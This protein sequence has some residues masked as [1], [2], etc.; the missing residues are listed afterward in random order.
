LGRIELV[1]VALGGMVGGGI[2]SVLGVAVD[3]VGKAAPLAILVGG[4]FAFF[5]AYSY[6]KLA[7]YYKDEGATYSFFKKTYPTNPFAASVIGW[8]VV[9]GFISTLALYAFTFSSYFLSFFSTHFFMAKEVV[10]GSI[11][12]LF[13][14]VNIVSVEGMGVLEDI[15]VYTKIV[16]LLV[17]SGLFISVG[18]INNLSPI[19]SSETSILAI[20]IVASITFVAFE[21]F[22]LVIHAYNETQNPD[23]NVPFAI[24][25]SLGAALFI[26]LILAIGAMSAIP[27]EV[28]ISDKEYA[29]AAG[30]KGIIGNIG[31]F[32]VIFGALLATSSAISG[33]LFGASRLMAVIADDGFLPK[34]LSKRKNDVIP[35]YSIMTMS[36]LAFALILTGGLQTI[37]E[38]GSITF[39]IVSMLMAIA[40]F[41]MRKETK[42]HGFISVIAIFTLFVGAVL[43]LYYEATESINN[44]MY[45]L[46]IYTLLTI[47]SY[48]YARRVKN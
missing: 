31:Q 28:L 26:Y 34:V 29:L 27:S 3:L 44:I 9:F 22:Q 32:I 35:T 41:K 48:A 39:I 21:G 19:L 46:G 33:T 13:A 37:L 2:F 25:T 18:D 14:I 16:I 12:L 43:L 6:A 10:A 40:N 1:A 38:F 11:I 15:L 20:F 45:I 4:I 5:A 47:F 42:T 23:R 8:F 7:V 30:A 36:L 24:Y 17:I